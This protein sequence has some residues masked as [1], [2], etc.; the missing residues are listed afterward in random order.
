M[1]HSSQVR[2]L[3][4]TADFPPLVWSGIGT[5]VANQAGAL[6][7]F[8][9]DVHVLA[10]ESL[11]LP[12]GQQDPSGFAVHA[13]SGR[14]FPVDVRRYDLLHLHSLALSELALEIKRRTGLPLI[15]TAHSL[16]EDELHVEKDA[17]FWIAIQ[18]IVMQI[19]DHVIFLNRA[20]RDRAIAMIPRLSTRSSVIPHPVPA[21]EG[22]REPTNASGPVVFAGRFTRNKGISTLLEVIQR[23]SDRPGFNFV[24][25]GGR[26]DGL[27]G[28]VISCIRER[29]PS[30]CRLAGWLGREQMDDLFSRAGVVLVP[31]FY[32][33]YGMVAL[34]AMRMGAPVL[35][36]AVG[37]LIEIVT[38]QS[39]GKLIYSHDP[40]EWVMEIVE[41]KEN[42][43]ANLRLRRQGPRYIETCFSSERFAGRLV[44][45]VYDRFLPTAR[46]SSAIA[47]RDSIVL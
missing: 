21:P 4:L 19:S 7:D 47:L 6:A 33:P 14:K 28:Q 18:K 16:V 44:H 39:G 43:A 34:E 41:L 2:L 3:V 30:S 26:A 45:E 8:G 37:G 1:L 38:P 12:I 36:A 22:R 10:P 46:H 11:Y 24:L 29:Y 13:L 31:S 17:D 23:L 27:G 25:A 35:A 40:D 5:A 15:Y 42:Q 20:E 32:E 9:L